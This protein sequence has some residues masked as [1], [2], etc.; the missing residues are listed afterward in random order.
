M[1]NDLQPSR[2]PLS[3]VNS[4]DNSPPISA[5]AALWQCSVPIQASVCEFIRVYTFSCGKATIRIEA[6]YRSNV[7]C[8][9]VVPRNLGYRTSMIKENEYAFTCVVGIACF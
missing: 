9:R 3:T 8:T 2:L 5:L 1:K 4:T 6:H 7:A